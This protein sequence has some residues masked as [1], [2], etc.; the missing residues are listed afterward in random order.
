MEKGKNIKNFGMIMGLVIGITALAGCSP[1]EEGEIVGDGN[2]KVM[3][4][5]GSY[6]VLR[7]TNTGCYYL[8]PM[9]ERS[10]SPLY[11]EDGKVKGCGDDSIS[12][13][14]Y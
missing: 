8:E 11:D 4:T 13:K 6:D 7:D 10:L 2:F 12:D 5:M 14:K 3:G 1:Y 9:N